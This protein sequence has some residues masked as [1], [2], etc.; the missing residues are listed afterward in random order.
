VI[1]VDIDPN[2]EPSEAM[3]SGEP[4]V[5]EYRRNIGKDLRVFKKEIMVKNHVAKWEF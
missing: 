5:Q 2:Y 3:L 1:F 4:Y